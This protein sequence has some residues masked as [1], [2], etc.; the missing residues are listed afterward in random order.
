[1]GPGGTGTPQPQEDTVLSADARDSRLRGIR[2]LSP[3]LGVSVKQFVVEAGVLVRA[4]ADLDGGRQ[5]G[6]ALGM[7]DL[8]D[9]LDGRK[10]RVEFTLHVRPVRIE[11]D[12]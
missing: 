7:K 8:V 9:G 6:R 3:S 1:M 5:A 4:R 2:E 11:S 12:R 10:D